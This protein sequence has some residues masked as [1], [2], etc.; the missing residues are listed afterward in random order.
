VAAH[1]LGGE[2]VVLDQQRAADRLA[3]S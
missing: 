1:D 3:H 2:I